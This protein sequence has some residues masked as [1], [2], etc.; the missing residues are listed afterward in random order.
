VVNDRGSFVAKASPPFD[1]VRPGTA[2]MP[3]GWSQE[4]F[5]KANLR[6]GDIPR[7][8]AQQ[9]IVET[10]YRLDILFGG[11]SASGRHRNDEAMAF[12]ITERC[13]DCE[14]ACS[15]AR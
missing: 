4:R 10:N 7:S 11:V 1:A 2:A 3:Q 9:R 12:G 8:E 6:S 5:W 13:I 15:R 14:H